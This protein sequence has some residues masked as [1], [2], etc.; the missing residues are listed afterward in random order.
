M[1]TEVEAFNFAIREITSNHYLRQSI[2]ADGVYMQKCDWS[3][4]PGLLDTE[5]DFREFKLVALTRPVIY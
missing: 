5:S 3:I 1:L 2:K 4:G